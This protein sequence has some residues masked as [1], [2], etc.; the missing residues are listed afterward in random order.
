[1]YVWHVEQM[2]REFVLYIKSSKRWKEN[3]VGKSWKR[4]TV[5]LS[6]LCTRFFSTTGGTLITKSTNF[7]FINKLSGSEKRTHSSNSFGTQDT[8]PDN[9]FLSKSPVTF[10]GSTLPSQI[11]TATQW[12]SLFTKEPSVSDIRSS[13]AAVR[14]P[15]ER[16]HLH[17]VMPKTIHCKLALIHQEFSSGRVFI[18]YTQPSDCVTAGRAAFWLLSFVVLKLWLGKRL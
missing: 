5:C 16:C 3:C 17:T 6:W 2:T 1:M 8:Q 10:F 18:P 12:S 11:I 7:H 14:I 13:A 15:P 9:H 4:V